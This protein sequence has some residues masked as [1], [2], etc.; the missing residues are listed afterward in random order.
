LVFKYSEWV[1]L[2]NKREFRQPY[3]ADNKLNFD[4]MLMLMMMSTLY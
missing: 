4:E 1:F 3:H 2:S